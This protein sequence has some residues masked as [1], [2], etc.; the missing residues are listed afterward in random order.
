[1]SRFFVEVRECRKRTNFHTLAQLKLPSVSLTT[2]G[3]F[4]FMELGKIIAE[5][6]SSDIFK[7]IKNLY[8]SEELEDVTLAKKWLAQLIG[9]QDADANLFV[10]DIYRDMEDDSDI[11]IDDETYCKMKFNTFSTSFGKDYRY[12]VTRIVKFKGVKIVNNDMEYSRYQVGD[13]QP[14][15][16]MLDAVCKYFRKNG[17]TLHN[18]LFK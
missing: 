1:M 12:D 11:I 15:Y 18:D 5:T 2:G 6:I 4:I 13:G 16:D 17:I 7:S 3:F 14:K 10:L 9:Q 8:Y